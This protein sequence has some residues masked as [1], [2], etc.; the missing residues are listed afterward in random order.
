MY[1]IFS[2]ECISEYNFRGR[3][4]LQYIA[5]GI[6]ELKPMEFDVADE[7]TYLLNM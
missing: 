7:D 4:Q 5:V 6:M 3:Y 2:D 1:V